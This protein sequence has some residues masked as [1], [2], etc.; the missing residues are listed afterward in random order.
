MWTPSLLVFIAWVGQSFGACLQV[1]GLF[2]PRVFIVSDVY[3]L[4]AGQ[5][6]KAAQPATWTCKPCERSCSSGLLSFNR[7]EVCFCLKP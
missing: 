6:G 1:F 7:D 2:I 4:A 5:E 3:D